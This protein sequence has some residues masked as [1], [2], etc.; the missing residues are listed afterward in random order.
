MIDFEQE[1]EEEYISPDVF[2]SRHDYSG[3]VI[4]S[5]IIISKHHK[6][7][8]AYNVRCTPCGIEYIRNISAIL[9]GRT[10]KC[11]KCSKKTG[12]KWIPAR[13]KE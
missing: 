6:D 10:S 3:R 5:W 8:Y 2:I 7:I 1:E 13:L 4:A 11:M 9:K 12:F